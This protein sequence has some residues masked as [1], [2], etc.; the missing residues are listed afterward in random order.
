VDLAVLHLS[1]YDGLAEALT[2][3]ERVL[4]G[5][6]PAT[7]PESP[8]T[9]GAVTGQVQRWLDLLGLE[10]SDNLLLTPA[11]GLAGASPAWAR[12]ALE[13]AAKAAGNIS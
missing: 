6:V 8:P 11:C 5:V 4:L 2:A 13:T 9:D 10:P 12:Q 3:G 1:A 7:R